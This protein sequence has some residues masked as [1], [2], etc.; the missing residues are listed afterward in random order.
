[1]YVSRKFIIYKVASHS[2]WLTLGDD[3]YIALYILYLQMTFLWPQKSPVTSQIPSITSTTDRTSISDNLNFGPLIT[4]LVFIP[5]A[6]HTSQL[7]I[8]PF[9]NS[10]RLRHCHYSCYT[11]VDPSPWRSTARLTLVCRRLEIA[12]AV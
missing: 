2:Q 6:F 10:R 5:R 12:V 7:P 8:F 3:F 9:H 4:S 11:M 1:M